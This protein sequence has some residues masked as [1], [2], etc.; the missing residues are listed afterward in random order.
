MP[1]NERRL[2]LV[3]ALS[4]LIVAAGC[5]PP[6]AYKAENQFRNDMAGQHNN[7]VLQAR[8]ACQ[9]A[10]DVDSCVANHASGCV[11]KVASTPDPYRQSALPSGVTESLPNPNVVLGD[12]DINP[13]MEGNLP[14]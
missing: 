13:Y 3:V 6:I 2:S 14:Y 10:E 4:M 7:C 11:G 8:A 12:P 1:M 9:G 5:L